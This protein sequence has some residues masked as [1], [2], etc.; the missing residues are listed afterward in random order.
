LSFGSVA[1]C[2]RLRS[3]CARC[4]SSTTRASR[5]QEVCP[6]LRLAGGVCVLPSSGRER[7]STNVEI[8]NI[9]EI[10]VTALNLSHG[11][12]KIMKNQ[13]I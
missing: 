9:I 3:A 2:Q 6:L 5:A 12:W 13:M 7:N 1:K 11:I 10:R 4:L 8:K